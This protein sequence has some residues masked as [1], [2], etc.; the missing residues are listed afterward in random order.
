MA[1]IFCDGFDHYAT[2]DGLKKWNQFG[3]GVSIQSTLGR[4]GGGCVQFSTNTR[5]IQKTLPS[6]YATLILGF[7]YN[8][9][10]GTGDV[11]WIM[12][13]GTTHLVLNLNASFG[14]TVLRSGTTLGSS[15]NG[16]VAT[17][18][19]THIEFKCTISDSVGTIDINVNGASV[20]SLSSQDTRNGGNATC[21]GFY[22]RSTAGGCQV[23]DVVALDNSGSSPTNAMLGDVRIDTIYP[24]ADGNYSQFTCSTGSSHYQLVDETTPNT[25]DYND[26]GTV[27]DR[28]SY[29]MGNLTTLASQTVYGVHVNL[30][31]N[32]DDAGSKSAAPFVRSG[33]TNTD[34]TST[35]LGTSQVYVSQMFEL[36]PN[37]GTAWTESTVNSME[38]GCKVTA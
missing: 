25:T 4:R 11:M 38:A 22:F 24:N 20:L 27:G 8:P 17:S 37:T 26:G 19:F 10:A 7:A 6:N 2:A 33:S 16:V 18:G 31:I 21:N 34:G 1:L 28:D 14:L 15:A 13:G 32:K 36:D 12:D 30:A 3:T 5:F 29:A 9:N 23:D 35:A